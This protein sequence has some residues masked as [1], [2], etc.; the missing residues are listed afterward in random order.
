M[1]SCHNQQSGEADEFDTFRCTLHKAVLVGALIFDI[2]VL[3]VVGGFAWVGSRLG[4]IRSA[5]RLAGAAGAVGLALLLREFM[6]TIVGALS[7][8]SHDLSALI[9]MLLVGA[10][11][12]MSLAALVTYYAGWVPHEHVLA[13]ERAFGAIPGALLGIGWVLGMAILLVLSPSDS[14]VSRASINSMTG[15][16]LIEN[17]SSTLHWITRN[18]PHYT[19]TLPKGKLGSVVEAKDGTLTVNPV[20]KTSQETQDAGQLLANINELRANRKRSQLQWNI[21]LAI[22]ANA[23]SS[24]MFTERFFAYASPAGKKLSERQEAALGASIDLYDAFG[25]QI[26]WS[27][28]VENAY[29]ALVDDEAALKKLLDKRWIE[30]GIGAASGGWFNGRMYTIL[31][32]GNTAAVKAGITAEGDLTR[33][34]DGES[35]DENSDSDNEVQPTTDLGL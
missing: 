15:S 13:T 33:I 27:H 32:V 9:G 4:L 30:I 31:F 28:S 7:P 21:D 26:V 18:F 17:G 34:S 23:N 12:Y 19:Q 25:R 1:E 5:V 35:S 10:G 14:F 2:L 24:K 16:Y 6:A 8:F 20:T 22:A 3:A 29:A 11:A